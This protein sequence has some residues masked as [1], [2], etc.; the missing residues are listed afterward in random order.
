MSR[1]SS[2][3]S[4]AAS[5]LSFDEALRRFRLKKD[6]FFRRLLVADAEL[7]A[8]ASARVADELRALLDADEPDELFISDFLPTVVRLA[9]RAP[10]SP[11][12]DALLELLE[13]VDAKFPDA[14]VADM[15]RA[16]TR[17][18][19]FI[20]ADQIKS[21]CGDS[22][23]EA[24]KLEPVVDN[25][26]EELSAL[27]R[28]SFLRA[29]RVTHLQ[30]LLGWHKDYLAL[31]EKASAA[32]ML[33]DGALPL[34]WRNYIAVM[35]AAE[36]RCHYLADLQ[37]YSFVVNGGDDEWLRGLDDIS[38]K[39][40]RLHELSSLLAHR[41]WLISEHHIAELLRSDAD[42]AWSV[43]ELVHALIVLCQ[44]HSMSSIALGLGCAEE[45]DLGVFGEF[46]DAF[47]LHHLQQQDDVEEEEVPEADE[48]VEAEQEEDQIGEAKAADAMSSCGSSLGEPDLA[49]IERDEEMVLKRLK[50]Y[51]GH[52]DSD[53]ADEEEDDA[54]GNDVDE[55]EDELADGFSGHERFEVAEDEADFGIRAHGAAH[56]RQDPLWRF[57]GGS[58]LRYADFDVRSD[59]YKVL[60]TED[61]S[62]DDHCFS[63][64]RRYFPGEAGQI[65]EDLFNL[66]G[67][68]TYDFFG[69]DRAAC[70][71]TSPYRDAVWYYV[72]RLFG[73]CHDDYDYSQVNTYLNRPTKM[74]IKKVACTPWKV[75]RADFEHFDRT[76]GASEKCHVVL[77]VAEARKQA[78][79]M[80]GLRAVMNHM[81]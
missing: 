22:A 41:P 67:K 21:G 76:L 54:S 79:L 60:H 58:V 75:R 59:E 49:A 28:A 4:S 38:P 20:A 10:F 6:G 27:F 39:L 71:D 73:I 23:G 46:G 50:K 56:R 74:F 78:G 47:A 33:R 69:A 30:Q 63:L 64:V 62:W 77:I 70:V 26:D 32:V 2:R 15:K 34:P 81:R 43:S 44:F 66:I 53:T 37:Q 24:D 25:Q 42:D 18:S 19:Y 29:G 5:A 1:V 13:D 65:L 55:E 31:F 7:Q 17:V 57:C 61:F 80:F 51:S 11:I 3:T 14:G 45:V 36:L 40:F 9:T 12:R 72:H 48:E 68:L 16:S 8:D 35:A 52:D